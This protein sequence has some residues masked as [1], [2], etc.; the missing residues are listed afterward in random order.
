M[1][2]NVGFLC[3]KPFRGTNKYQQFSFEGKDSRKRDSNHPW[4]SEACLFPC[5]GFKLFLN[6]FNQSLSITSIRKVET[7]V[8]STTSPCD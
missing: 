8:L 5:Y 7:E 3:I 6:L 4:P 2:P 1:A